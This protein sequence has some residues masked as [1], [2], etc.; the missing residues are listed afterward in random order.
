MIFLAIDLGWISQPSGLARIKPSAERAVVTALD[1][2]GSHANVLAWIDEQAGVAPAMLAI[3]APLVIPNPA[4]IRDC[5]RAVNADFRRHHAGC[6]AANRS[7]PFYAPLAAFV[8]E[9]ERRGYRHAAAISPGVPGRYM[10][11]VHPHAAAVSV[12]GLDRIIKYKKGRLADRAREL[13]RLRELLRSLVGGDL[14]DIPANGRALKA[15]EDQPDAVFAAWIGLR[16]WQHGAAGARCYGSAE[17]GY[18]VVPA[19]T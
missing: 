5:E 16:W 2:Q 8:I 13:T 19:K 17:T 18:I 14:P 12:F 10:I 7:R 9:L 4:G 11:E 1:R 15:A 6:H 3:D